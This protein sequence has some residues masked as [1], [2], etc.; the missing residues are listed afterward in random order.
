MAVNALNRPMPRHEF[1]C[2]PTYHPLKFLS[3]AEWPL[4]APVLRCSCQD[5]ESEDSH[6]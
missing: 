2:F 6:V 5:N 1:C 4:R 3:K